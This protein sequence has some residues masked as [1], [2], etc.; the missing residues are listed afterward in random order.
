MRKLLDADEEWEPFDIT[1][2]RSMVGSLMYLTASRPDITLVVTVCAQ[3]QSNPKKS[4]SKAMVRI[5]QYLKDRKITSG[6]IQMLESRLVGWSSKKQNCV[7]LST[8]E[9][10]YIAAAQFLMLPNL[11]CVLDTKS[12]DYSLMVSN[13]FVNS[14]KNIPVSYWLAILERHQLCGSLSYIVSVPEQD[15]RLLNRTIRFVEAT[16]PSF[17]NPQGEPA[18]F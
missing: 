14:E 2:Y 13:Y 1:L 12:D 16:L 6:S 15:L 11:P 7:S 8:T 9:S 10:E 18:R 3:F 17:T 4:H 5:F